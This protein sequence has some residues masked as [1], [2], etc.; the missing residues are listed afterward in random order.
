MPR[1]FGTYL[2]FIFL[3]VLGAIAF[4]VMFFSSVPLPAKA[5]LPE[6]EIIRVGYLSQDR[7]SHVSQLRAEYGYSYDHLQEIAQY[8]NWELEF[9]PLTAKDSIKSLLDGRIDILSHVHYDEDLTSKID[10]SAKESGT[11]RVGLYVLKKNESIKQNDL[12]FLNMKRIG[13]FAPKKHIQML[14]RSITDA[15]IKVIYVDFDENT[16]LLDALTEGS[17][18]GALISGNNVPP[19]FEIIRVFP[20]EPFY[21]AV[22]EGNTELLSKVDNAMHD[23]ILMNPSFKNDLFK[24][25]YSKNLTWESML[26]S[27]EREFIKG[28]PVLIVSYDPQWQ[29]FEYYDREKKSMAGIDYEVLKLVKDYT[30]LKMEI[31]HSTTWEEAL[32]R[33]REGEIDILTGVNR[34]F[35]WGSK[36]NF[37]ITRP[38]LN[39]PIVMVMNRKSGYKGERIA[40]PKNY[41][42]SE[43][44]ESFHKFDDTVY[45][46]SQED[47]FD[48]LTENKVSATF[49]NSY[50]ANYLI[51]LPRYS[52][53]YTINYSDLNEQ[54]AFGIS[55][56]CDTILISII[57]KA[58][59]SIPEETINGI[60]IKHSYSKEKVSF[61]DIIYEHDVE[62]AKGLTSV[63]VVAVIALTLINITKSQDKRNLK[64][65]L[66]HDRVTGFSNYN[67]FLEEAPEIIR[68]NPET[69]FAVLF[70]DIVEFK[71]INGSFGYDEGDAVL[72]NVA[73]VLERIIDTSKETFARIAAD[74][75][76]VL[77]SYEKFKSIDIRIKIIFGELEKLASKGDKTYNILFNGGVYLIEDR[78]ISLNIAVDNAGFAKSGITQKHKTAYAYYDRKILVRI[79]KEKEI[80]TSMREALRKGEFVP[81]LQAKIDLETGRPV[82]AESLVRWIKKDGEVIPPSHFIP[83]FEKSGFITK[84]DMYMFGETC[85]ILRKW[86]DEDREILPLSC[87]FSYLDIAGNS[88]TKYLKIMSERHRVPPHLLELEL[89]ESVAAQH[90]DLVNSRGRELSDYGFRLSID[91]FGSGYSSLSL[92]QIL[93]IDVLKLDRDFVQR[94]LSGKLSHDLVEGLVS[95]FKNNSVQMVFEGIETE[96]QVNFVRSLGCRVVQGYYY[97]KPLPLN[98]FEEKYLN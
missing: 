90:I 15:G 80:E 77:L 18:D 16:S 11:C 98:E 34:S 10:Y 84:I 33:M 81:F 61:I 62:L 69:N 3:T 17:V 12:R 26:T 56:K 21:I 64:K 87:N 86:I 95:A 78:S 32:R 60:I 72:K 25:H 67:R 68:K 70:I 13:R 1:S 43:V 94:G 75:F 50:V 14:E 92:L 45:L 4:Q 63:L 83:Y 91:D 66:Y 49:A 53:L 93:K 51:S 8:Y 9:I 5:E 19:D 57:N 41:F 97:S 7:S 6:P 54:V 88:F 30:G 82:G 89:T 40:L 47:C 29:P 59:N 37:R 28:S 48:A 58:L 55:K 46:N 35:V 52:D 44:V 20:E 24:K 73:L 79:N 74:H 23:I 42:L 85:R 38:F 71:F 2:R 27:K 36:N 39:A 76:A 96:E 22:A 31:S 65:L